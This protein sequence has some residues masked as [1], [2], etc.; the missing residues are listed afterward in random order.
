MK[1][2][3]GY[4]GTPHISSNDDQGRNQGI[5]GT[6]NY[7]LDVGQRFNATLTNATT[8]TLEDGE[9]MMQG[10][11]FRIEPGMTEAVSISPGTSGYNRIDLICAKYTKD[12]STGTEDVSL[13]VVEGTPTTGA[14]IEPTYTNGDIL[15]GDTLAYMVLWKVALSGLTPGL[16]RVV[17]TDVGAGYWLIEGL[18]QNISGQS[19]S[20]ISLQDERLDNG[21]YIVVGAAQANYSSLFPDGYAVWDCGFVANNVAFPRVRIQYSGGDPDV[22]QRVIISV[23]N[24]SVSAASYKYRVLLKKLY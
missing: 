21:Q 23:Y 20:D 9:G 10:V 19:S 7:I 17:P 13:V 5:F 2:V 18:A 16:V 14:A 15:A 12:T 1:I 6:G 22:P 24:S 4:T 11:H 8:V 3:T